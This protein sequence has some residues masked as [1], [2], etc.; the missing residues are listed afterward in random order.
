MRDLKQIFTN[1]IILWGKSNIRKFSW[2]KNKIPYNILISELLLQRT[3]S[4]QVEKIFPNFIKEF[5][6]SRI[7]ANS[8]PEKI[9]EVIKPLGLFRRVNVLI[10]MANQ[11]EEEYG[12]KIPNNYKELINLFGVGKY[13]A[14]AVLCFSYNQKVPII[15]TNI[16]RIFQRFF[17]FKSNKKYI[18]SDKKIWE[19]AED[20]LPDTDFQLYNYSLLDFGNL[21]C[22]SKNPMCKECINKK[23]CLFIN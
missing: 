4:T 18:E 1:N 14:N 13:I 3:T 10:K 8:D 6:N 15:D 21:I 22:K 19:L 12:G 20:L 23:F 7:L 11:I 17:S 16:I 9:F 5:P 2:R